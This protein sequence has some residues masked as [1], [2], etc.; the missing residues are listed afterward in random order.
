MKYETLHTDLEELL[1]P[2]GDPQSLVQWMTKSMSKLKE[3]LG[4]RDTQLARQPSG[5]FKRDG[6]SRS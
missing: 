2:K 3:A 4:A 1:E 6:Y 5:N